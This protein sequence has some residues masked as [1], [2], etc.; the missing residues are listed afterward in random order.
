MEVCSLLGGLQVASTLEVVRV[1]VVDLLFVLV[2]DLEFEEIDSLLKEVH[3]AEVLDVE[4]K[5][6]SGTVHAVL[7][8]KR[9]Y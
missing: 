9:N 1:C 8:L 3:V 2:K 7:A 6:S 5:L 4:H